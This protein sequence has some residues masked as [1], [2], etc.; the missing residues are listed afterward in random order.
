M[1]KNW[2]LRLCCTSRSE[3]SKAALWFCCR[4]NFFYFFSFPRKFSVLSR[5]HKMLLCMKDSFLWKS[6][7]QEIFKTRKKPDRYRWSDGNRA[8]CRHSSCKRP[9][10]LDDCGRRRKWCRVAANFEIWT[11][12]KK[13]SNNLFIFDFQKLLFFTRYNFPRKFYLLQ[14]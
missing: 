12:L 2:F 4:L 10:L 14:T 7:S 5:E 3:A 9:D 13:I 1:K 11:I 8:R 6:S